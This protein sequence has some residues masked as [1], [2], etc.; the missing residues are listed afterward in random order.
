LEE[1][2]L[3]DL[4]FAVISVGLVGVEIDLPEKSVMGAC[5]RL[6]LPRRKLVLAVALGLGMAKSAWPD[7]LLLVMLELTDHLVE[8]FEVRSLENGDAQGFFATG[9]TELAVKKVRD[10]KFVI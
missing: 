3:A 4:M 10:N 8:G 9:A 2:A 5:Q 6:F 1:V 7:L